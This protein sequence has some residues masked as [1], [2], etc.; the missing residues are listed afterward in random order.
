LNFTFFY[1]S[2]PSSSAPLIFALQYDPGAAHLVAT[3]ILF[4]LLFGGPFMFISA[5]FLET[6][7]QNMQPLVLIV[8]LSTSIA[9]VISGIIFIILILC[10]RQHWGFL[11]VGRQLLLVYA[12]VVLVYEILMV[13]MNPASSAAYCGIFKHTRFFPMGLAIGWLQNVSRLAMIILLYSSVVYGND[14]MLPTMGAACRMGLRVAAACF[15]LGAVSAICFTPNTINEVCGVDAAD[16]NTFQV[17]VDMVWN[18]VLL[19]SLLASIIK[20]IFRKRSSSRGSNYVTGAS[21]D[22]KLDLGGETF[23]E[24]APEV[25]EAAEQTSWLCAPPVTIIQVLSTTMTLRCLTTVVNTSQVLF[26]NKFMPH[27]TKVFPRILPAFLLRQSRV[28][29]VNTY[30]ARAADSC[31]VAE[32]S[33]PLRHAV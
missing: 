7:T 19:L 4:G 2:L 1:G 16:L 30:E 28:A 24:T 31:A 29:Y 23:A 14:P 8:Q 17:V 6:G 18:C 27:L 5:L 20:G 12:C 3:A 21:L 11:C 26:D 9:S 33:T 15:V 25:T 22:S 10:L 32:V 13:M